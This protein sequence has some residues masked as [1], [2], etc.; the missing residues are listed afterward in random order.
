MMSNQF[1]RWG[2][3]E[4]PALDPSTALFDNPYFRTVWES[5]AEAMALSD[6]QGIVLAA[7]RAYLQLYELTPDEVIGQSFACIFPEAARLQAIQRYKEVFASEGPLPHTAASDGRAEA[8][9]S[10]EATVQRGNGEVR[11]VESRIEFIYEEGRRVAML[12]I[13]RDITGR[14]QMEA[15]L[16]QA[17]EKVEVRV[18][19]RTQGL[20]EVNASLQA[21]IDERQRIET[22]L[23]ASEVQLRALA[24]ELTMAEQ[25]ERGR[26]AQ[27]LHDDL[28]QRL[29]SVRVLLQLLV[30]TTEGNAQADQVAYAQQAYAL[31]GDTIGL[32]RQLTID[33]S[34]LVLKEEGL[35]DMFHWLT[36]Q[37]AR[38]HGLQVEVQAPHRF[39]IAHED[40]RVLL[41]QIVRELLFNVVKHAQTH[42]A[43]IELMEDTNGQLVIQVS[44]QGQGFDVATAEARH[45]GSFGLFSVRK[46]LELFGGQMAIDSTPGQG[47]RIT[48]STPVLAL[49]G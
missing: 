20:Q 16:H 22:A 38:L 1:N 31:L 27:I 44:D 43:A 29:Y 45:T 8:A 9:P 17:Q 15:A 6:A 35:T 3:T 4:L 19:E 25:A 36:T 33:L 12:S 37:M 42:H 28:Q 49:R 14:K 24:S 34:P 2:S 41:F 23:R 39:V 48:L 13:I 18:Q 21:E 30:E 10:F 11:T 5:T 7:N 40:I 47:T 32:T 46:R 26:I